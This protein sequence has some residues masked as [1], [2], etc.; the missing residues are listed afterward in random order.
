MNSTPDHFRAFVEAVA[1]SL[2]AGPR[3]HEG[4]AQLHLSRSQLDR[5]VIAAGGEAPARLVRRIL[6]ERAAFRLLEGKLRI[7]DVAFEAGYASHEGISL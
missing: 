3:T 6:L 5:I 1:A 4:A 2:D 7:L